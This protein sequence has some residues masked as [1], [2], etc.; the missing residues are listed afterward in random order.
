MLVDTSSSSSSGS[1]LT[2]RM[3]P[4]HL[5]RVQERCKCSNSTTSHPATVSPPP[6]PLHSA[7]TVLIWANI[8]YLQ[9]PPLVDCRVIPLLSALISMCPI[10]VTF[11]VRRTGWPRVDKIHCVIVMAILFF[12]LIPVLIAGL[13]PWSPPAQYHQCAV[14]SCVCRKDSFNWYNHSARWGEFAWGMPPI[15]VYICVCMHACI[16]LQPEV[17]RLSTIVCHR[18]ASYTVVTPP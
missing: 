13:S 15:C 12:C 6:S 4:K 14:P 11:T 16:C 1:L 3:Y 10:I 7:A 17:E 5:A 18:I 2:F 9:S 8:N